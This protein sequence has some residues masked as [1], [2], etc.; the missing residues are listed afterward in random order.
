MTPLLLPIVCKG[1]ACV[2]VVGQFGRQTAN[3]FVVHGFSHLV[4]YTIAANNARAHAIEFY[5]AFAVASLPRRQVW[6]VA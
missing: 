2:A 4:R 5:R 6:I 3:E 1:F